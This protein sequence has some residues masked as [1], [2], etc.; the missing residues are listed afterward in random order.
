MTNRRRVSMLCAILIALGNGMFLHTVSQ[1]SSSAIQTNHFIQNPVELNEFSLA[2]EPE[3]FAQ[4]GRFQP[5][6]IFI[7]TNEAQLAAAITN[8]NANGQPDIIDITADIGLT[9]PLPQILADGGNSL[10]INGNGGHRTISRTSGIFRIFYINGSAAVVMM[11]DLTISNGLIISTVGAGILNTGTLTLT[12]CTISNN[13]IMGTPNEGGGIW[14]DGNLTLTN[15][16]VSGNSTVGFGGGIHHLNTVL[17][18]T[19]CLFSGNTS[20]GSGGGGL[21]VGSDT[22]MVTGCTFTGN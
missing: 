9:S 21:R 3:S 14:S 10:T 13:T 20:S 5:A 19:N 15:C 22:S 18:V 8:A 11:N 7:V 17:T 1:A 16:T 12:N 6:A 2:Q 4:K